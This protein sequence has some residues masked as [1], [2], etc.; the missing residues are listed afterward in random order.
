MRKTLVMIVFLFV[1]GCG[2]AADMDHIG[3]V[4]PAA[5]LDGNTAS[6]RTAEASPEQVYEGNLILVNRKFPLADSA[7]PSDVVSL[8]EHQELIPGVRLLDDSIRLSQALTAKFM[9]MVK[10]AEADGVDH[11]MISSGY[12]NL[13]EQ[14]L[15]YTQKGSGYALPPGY[16]EH[17]A[18]LSLDIGSTLGEMENAPEGKWLQDNAWKYGF[19]L[20]YPADKT[21]VTGIE[22]EPWHFRYVGLPHSFVMKSEDMVLEEYLDYLKRE[23]SV[24]VQIGETVYL[25]SYYSSADGLTGIPVPDTKE[26]YELSGDNREGLIV[27]VKLG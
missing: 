26:A 19:I 6:Y 27:T 9:D 15:L 17:N 22:Y 21:A 25:V 12:R 13:D 4:T 10:A 11:F 20:R 16:S 18:G 8:I 3:T 14:R 7:A 23:Q 24:R 2:Q 1:T 5:K